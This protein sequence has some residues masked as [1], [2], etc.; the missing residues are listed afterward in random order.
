MKRLN[1]YQCLL[2][3]V[4]GI[5]C[6]T[7]TNAGTSAILWKTLTALGRGL[8]FFETEYEKLNLDAIIGTRLVDGE[9]FL[10]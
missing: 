9:F 5:V 8:Q 2:I 1:Q 3:I 10:S 4:T 6:G 7:R